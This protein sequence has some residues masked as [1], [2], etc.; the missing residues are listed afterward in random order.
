MGLSRR[1]IIFSIVSIFMF[2]SLILAGASVSL[3]VNDETRLVNQEIPARVDRTV[4]DTVAND[5]SRLFRTSVDTSNNIT[6]NELI[7]HNISGSVSD[8]EEFMIGVYSNNTISNISFTSKEEALYLSNHSKITYGPNKTWF[9]LSS[10]ESIKYYNLRVNSSSNAIT[11][12]SDW[13]WTTN[14]VYVNLS[15]SDNNGSINTVNG[16][17]SGYVNPGYDNH[18]NISYADG[19]NLSISLSN[20]LL[21]NTSGVVNTSTTLGL[22][23]EVYTGH[24][25]RIDNKVLELVKEYKTSIE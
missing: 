17:T 8:Y 21:L 12:N 13:A 16:S 7:P 18:F 3:R 2:F 24:V 22:K 1:G 11:V 5:I 10:N 6:I 15:I 20:R 4:Y 19:S 23:G 14:G 25:L 9:N